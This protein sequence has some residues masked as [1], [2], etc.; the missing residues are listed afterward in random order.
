MEIVIIHGEHHTKSYERL[1][2][3][4]EV[5]K[6]RNWEIVRFDSETKDKKI[7]E[8]IATGSLFA[9]E[10]LFIIEYKFLLKTDITWINKNID[11][12]PGRVVIFAMDLLPTGVLNS[13]KKVKKVELFKIPRNIFTFL[14]SFY[15]KN[16]KDCLETL[17]EIKNEEPVEFIFSLLG[18]HLRDLYWVQNGASNIPYPSW[19]VMRLESQARKFDKDRLFR[20]INALAL[21][22]F[23]AKTSQVN[24]EESLDLLIVENLE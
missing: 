17:A 5:A 18:K 20:I 2:K 14:T 19:R 13:F 15:P 9:K 8:I 24:L 23:Q 16:T 12:I 4:I 22:D 7:P 10:R 3:Y 11:H 6:E 1:Q 21:V